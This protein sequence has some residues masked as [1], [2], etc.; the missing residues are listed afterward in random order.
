M[1]SHGVNILYDNN[2]KEKARSNKYFCAERLALCNKFE[3]FLYKHLVNQD[4]KKIK[5]LGDIRYDFSWIRYLK[6]LNINNIKKKS[7]NKNIKL[8]YVMGNLNFLK[9]KSIEEK[10]N[11][12]IAKLSTDISNLELWVKVHPKANFS[13]KY[14]KNKNLKVFQKETDISVL[15]QAAD[16][17]LTTHSGVLTESIISGKYNI[18]YDSWKKKLNNPWTVF[19][20]TPCVDKVNNYKNLKEKILNFKKRK[21]YSNNDVN[22]FYKKYISGNI[23]LSKSI[24]NNY[25]KEINIILRSK[26]NAYH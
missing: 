21:K 7:N 17:V 20:L 15:L 16:I 14:I 25:I 8:L 26:K 9:D 1:I 13:F 6:K 2:S 23:S 3:I 19:D 4:K 10:I 11:Q 18:L 24:I 5:L 12:D 22:N